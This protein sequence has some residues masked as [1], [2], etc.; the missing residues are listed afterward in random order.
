MIDIDKDS[1]FY[2]DNTR[3]YGNSTSH[4]LVMIKFDLHNTFR[5][6]R[7]KNI[8]VRARMHSSLLVSK[9]ESDSRDLDSSLG[10][11]HCFEFLSNTLTLRG[12]FHA[13]V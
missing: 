9:S 13:G 1:L 10:R 8:F 12:L 6:R 3:S 5:Q 2:L 11:G 4:G 7:K